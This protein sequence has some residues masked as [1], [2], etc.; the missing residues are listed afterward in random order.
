MKRP[1]KSRLVLV[2]VILLVASHL[3]RTFAP[4]PRSPLPGQATAQLPELAR[5]GT[6]TGRTV[7]VAYR[8]IGP[9]SDGP[10]LVL[11]HGSPLASRSFDPILPYLEG[12]GI[13]LIIPDLPGFGG[14]THDLT[15]YSIRSH[16]RYLS[17]L[18]DH[19]TIPRAHLLGYSQGGGVAIEFAGLAPPRADSLILLS[20]IGV[21]ELELLG[22]YGLNQALYA[23]QLGAIWLVQEGTPHFGWWDT[24]LLNL[25]Y[26]RN[27]VD[28]DQRP[29]R[30]I[31]THWQKPA[32]IIQGREDGLV[33]HA[34]A[35]EHARIL[36]QA[37]TV[38]LPGGHGLVFTDP[39]E[40]APAILT[41][42]KNPDKTTR[43]TAPSDRIAEASIPF[44][45]RRLDAT[46]TGLAMVVALLV[47]ATFVSEDLACISAGVLVSQGVV[48]YLAATGGCLLGIFVG[49]IG[50]FLIG[51]WI[52]SRAL[53][54]APLRW[55]ID[56]DRAERARAFFARRGLA[57]IF[58]TRFLPGTRLPTFVGAGLAGA[59]LGPFLVVFLASCIVWTPLLV[60]VAALV[61]GAA[62]AAFER[63]AGAAIWAVLA[64]GFLFFLIVRVMM[65]AFTWKGR[66]LLLSRW[67][68]LR[69][70]E[71][72]PMWAFY[73][74]VVVHVLWLGLRHRNL[75]LFTAADPAI[76]CGG[77]VMESKAEILTGLKNSGALPPFA[78]LPDEPLPGRYPIVLKPDVGERGQGVAIAVD[79]AAAAAYLDATPP[80]TRTIAQAFVPGEEFG[81]FY[82]RLPSESRGRVFSLTEKRLI[83]VTGD[84]VR[85]L[86]ELILAD[87]RA[88]CMA[89]FF[90]RKH[91]DSLAN[92]PAAGEVVPLT[93][94]GTHCRGALFLDASEHITPELESAIDRISQSFPGFYFG[95]YDLR[96]PSIADLRAG[97]RIAVLELNGVSSEAT[98]IYDPRHGLFHAYRTLFAQ[99]RLCF[100]IARENVTRGAQPATLGEIRARFRQFRHKESFDAPTSSASISP[101]S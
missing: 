48:G 85:T 10:T 58:A 36:P 90:L 42:L 21:Q 78:V 92:V 37:E 97:T 67:R 20:S 52:G 54:R 13:R 91:G 82:T 31:L 3:T 76:P 96:V 12:R 62:L 8:D 14:S 18:L 15:D 56:A 80:G 83:S 68:R 23:L 64:L 93:H 19:L 6:A 47:L 41:F 60:G 94:V 29:L 98:H 69:C 77:L 61:G 59:P 44:V 7:E 34:V 79:R 32:L 101:V 11:L 38:F 35:I 28:S 75:T 53:H 45:P 65:P 55:F 27:F 99:W 100:A 16:A 4:A 5:D 24:A 49:D 95:R 51:R 74:P 87:D 88:V 26:A 43:A 9:K 2:Y 81:V 73:P 17:A 72:W 50:L 30:E 1:T 86:E 57:L 70:W 66:R 89:R 25:P 63:Y 40:I 39:G 22:D 84:G 46:A 71:F 33:P